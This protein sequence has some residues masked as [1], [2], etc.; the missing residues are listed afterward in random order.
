M[1]RAEK[2]EFEKLVRNVKDL[3]AEK[4]EQKLLSLSEGDREAIGKLK[5]LLKEKKANRQAIKAQIDAWKKESGASGLDFALAMQY[6]DMIESEKERLEKVESGIEEFEA[7]I[8][9]LTG[10]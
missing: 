9:K 1:S 10:R 4:K 6:N 2:Q 8:A 7:M 3:I 5:E